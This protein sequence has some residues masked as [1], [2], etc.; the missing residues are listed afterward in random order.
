MATYRGGKLSDGTPLNVA[1]YKAYRNAG[2]SHSQALAVT[3]EVGRENSFNAGTLFGNHTDPAASKNGKKIRNLGMLSWNQGRDKMLEGYLVKNGVMKNGVMAKNQSN[4][5]A[6]AAFSVREMKSPLYASKLK[7]FWGNPNASPDTYARELGKHYIAWAYGQDTI[8]AQGGGRKA[9]NW[10]ANDNR[11]RGYLNTLSGML[12]G[13]TNYQ[14]QP[15]QQAPDPRLSMSAPDLLTSLRKGKEKRSDNQIFMELANNNGLA[16]REINHLLSQGANPQDIAKDLGLNVSVSQPQQEAR[17]S[18]AL[19]DI[20][21]SYD[22]FMA[23]IDIQDTNASQL[24]D[25]GDGYDDFMSKIQVDEPQQPASQTPDIGSSYDDFMS[26][27][28]VDEPQQ[29]QTQQLPDIGNDY[30]DFMS[31]LDLAEQPTQAGEPWQTQNSK[32]ESM[33][34]MKNEKAQ[35]MPKSSW[36]LPS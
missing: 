18:N 34:Q 12:G 4:L 5:N 6:Q 14:G 1:V 28:Q 8:K 13:N 25:I 31:K 11:R 23:G 9:F 15:Q 29:A 30:D 7:N 33:S 26:K 2:L 16:G 19:P 32:L 3:A 36:E 10:K 24:P 35:L 17:V 22:D 27:L 21:A 20:G